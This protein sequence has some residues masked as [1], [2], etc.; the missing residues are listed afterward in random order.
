MSPGFPDEINAQGIHILF[1][2]SSLNTEVYW[3][4]IH[5][6]QYLPYELLNYSLLF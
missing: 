6:S 4:E 2:S 5:F 3:E 1:H